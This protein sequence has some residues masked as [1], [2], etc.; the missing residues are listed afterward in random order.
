MQ[1]SRLDET[2]AR[3]CFARMGAVPRW[4]R[5]R[6]GRPLYPPHFHQKIIWMLRNFNKTTSEPWWRTPGTQKGHP[7]YS[8]GGRMK[9]K[10][11]KE[12]Q[13]SQGQKP[14]L[15]R[16]FWRRSLHTVGNPLTS[17]SLGS[18]GIS[19]CNII[20]R[21]EKKKKTPQNICLTAIASGEV[22]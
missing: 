4:Q 2:Q 16:E 20:G 10:R 12:R 19:D 13:N 11:Q 6:T 15:R 1:N 22:V 9:Y 14:F 17:R 18:F 8:K 7:F 3:I 5:N 21:E